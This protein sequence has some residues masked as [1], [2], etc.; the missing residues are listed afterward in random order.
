MDYLV[1]L[2]H[3]T[4]LSEK[5][6]IAIDVIIRDFCT[7]QDVSEFI[8]PQGLS[9]EQRKY[10]HEKCK[11]LGL[12]SKS[13]GKEPHRKLHMSKQSKMYCKTFYLFYHED[14]YRHTNAC[15]QRYK[16]Y[17]DHNTSRRIVSVSPVND[18]MFGR[19]S[20]G[21][22]VTV[23]K[24]ISNKLLD[25]RQNLPVWSK[26]D[27]FLQLLQSNQ[28]VIVTSETGS[29]KSTQI[30]Q[31]ILE[32][33]CARRGR[34]KI[35]CTQP[36]RLSTV[37]V[38]ERVA[39]ERGES[40][41]HT[42]GYQIKLKYLCSPK[43][44]LMYCTNGI[45]LRTL[46]N[47][48]E[49]YL[50]NVTHVIV[51]EIHE[52]DK[53]TDFLLICL[54]QNM[55]LYRNLK[56]ILMS[57]TADIK[58]FASYFKGAKILHVP[59]RNHSITQLFLEDILARINHNLDV[60]V[61]VKV[62]KVVPVPQ[63][64]FDY[65]FEIMN[66]VISK[67]MA[68]GDESYFEQLLHLILSENSNVNHQTA[69]GYTPLMAAA[70]HGKL[71]VV[72]Q[73]L[74]LGSRSYLKSFPEGFTAANWALHYAKFDVHQLLQF[75]ET[76]QKEE[77]DRQVSDD[78]D[79][80]TLL[81]M[82][83]RTVSEDTIDFALIVKVIAY[84][85]AHDSMGTIL[86]FLPGYEDIIACQEKI[87]SSSL[88]NP[89]D[90]EL[91][92]L[93]GSM[94]I[95]AQH[96]V[97]KIVRSKHKII[98]STNIAETSLTI[99]DVV[100]VIDTGRAK[101][102][103]YDSISGTCALQKIWISKA[104]VQQR[105]GRSGRTGPGICFHLF[106]KQ[107]YFSLP[108]NQIPEMFRVPLH[109]VCLQTKYLAPRGVSIADYLKLALEPPPVLSVENSIENLKTLSALTEDE[110]LT[111]LGQHLIQLSIDPVL[112]KM[113]IYSIVFKCLDPVLTIV[114]CLAYRDPFII[115]QQA[116]LKQLALKKQ[117]ELSGNC[118]SDHLTLLRA[119]QLWQE[120]KANPG[121]RD[122]LDEYFISWSAM[123]IIH[124]TRTQ[125]LS[126]LRGVGFINLQ[127]SYVMNDLNVNSN[128][129]AIVKC[130]LTAGC[131]PNI[132]FTKNRH[133]A[134]KNEKRVVFNKCSSLNNL[135]HNTSSPA[136]YCIIYDELSKI[137]QH[138]SIKFG[139]AVTPMTVALICGKNDT[140]D[141]NSVVV[142]DWLNF[143]HGNSN[144]THFRKVL[145]EIIDKKISN[146]LYSFNLVE[147]EVLNEMC[148][149]LTFEEN[150]HQLPQPSNLGT[151]PKAY[152]SHFSS[153]PLER[154]YNYK[155]TN[156]THD[157]NSM[158]CNNL[159]ITSSNNRAKYRNSYRSY[160]G[161]NAVSGPESSVK[162][163]NAAYDL[164]GSVSS[165]EYY[166][167][168]G[169]VTNGTSAH[170]NLE[171]SKS[172]RDILP[173][174]LLHFPLNTAFF[175]VKPPN[176]ECLQRG[177]S[178][179]TWVFAPQSE[180]K[181]FKFFNQGYFIIL[182]FNISKTSEFQGFA[183]LLTTNS[184]DIN[185]PCS[186]HWLSTAIVSFDSIRDRS[187]RNPYNNNNL[188]YKCR[189]GQGVE[190]NVGKQLCRMFFEQ[191]PTNSQFSRR[192]ILGS[193]RN[194]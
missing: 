109:E 172:S 75:Y 190:M 27:E 28:V 178:L 90:F 80:S 31:F 116:N 30:P 88:F 162:R 159:N 98:L 163:R 174:D 175:I 67:C 81:E 82:Y 17:V 94:N 105:A 49:D 180:R 111:M 181:I 92:M 133:Y 42:V 106:S 25:F 191:T 146:P 96:G 189:D 122:V 176:Y 56:I 185:Q 33:V 194:K 140:N 150:Q 89:K 1:D 18:Q 69:K 93:H 24:P 71:D 151:S 169:C 36:R 177:I 152:Y 132:C 78:F 11:L 68:T 91:F 183:R 83:D 139:T 77:S 63:N 70:A 38:A 72:E 60:N 114:S 54:R 29:G 86:I 120:V 166:N 58:L 9:N 182:F 134:T 112:G 20:M 13:Q 110:E 124:A 73:L 188:V 153:K 84:I 136:D 2:T 61:P 118:L 173:L 45:L 154:N 97:F 171:N 102:K 95:N 5:F 100:Y 108:D 145:R 141:D 168:N 12:V 170:S 66:D 126:Q 22:T 135:Q 167:Y 55:Q 87:L 34:C 186:L 44:A 47:N 103:S 129:W 15:L 16:D 32:E 3:S 117:K 37:A 192:P 101:E 74:N 127:K 138:C 125:L 143:Q 4:G 23:N 85:H 65:E 161:E 142:D 8:F 184:G 104:N 148:R 128:N 53:Y 46:M 7:N 144:L 39:E 41:G 119:F 165:S 164:R 48:N 52:R 131:Y 179:S 147:I 26:R 6:R 156:H 19:L 51:D 35:I 10:I 137:G 62:N 79:R 157:L 76:L 113:L 160:N 43:S 187:L 14:T 115:P 130:A 99:S 57:A 59:G 193:F 64:D 50:K 123:E 155:R 40:V 121:K 158:L 149:I 107:R 21:C